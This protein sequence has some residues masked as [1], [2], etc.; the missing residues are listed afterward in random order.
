[1]V[2][3]ST[4]PDLRGSEP[5]TNNAGASLKSTVLPQLVHNGPRKRPFF[6][7]FL[8]YERYGRDQIMKKH[9]TAYW[10]LPAKPEREL[11]CDIIRILVKQFGAPNF[12]PHV[13]LLVTGQSRL[14]PKKV[15]QQ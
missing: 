4:E 1:M 13:T 5:L 6:N 9:A 3:P 15:L 10:L 8:N 12:E 11:L 14:A 7:R 2:K